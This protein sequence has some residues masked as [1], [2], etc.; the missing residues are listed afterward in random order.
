MATTATTCGNPE[1]SNY[2]FPTMS[3]AERSLYC[4]VLKQG[5]A[6]ELLAIGRAVSGP[7]QHAMSE[8]S[9][10]ASTVSADAKGKGRGKAKPK[11]APPAPTAQAPATAAGTKNGK[12]KIRGATAQKGKAK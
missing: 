1:A 2:L 3:H 6:A 5:G 10:Q 4:S 12:A 8:V 7:A 9:S 11:G